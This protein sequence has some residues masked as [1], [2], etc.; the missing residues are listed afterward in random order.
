M[1]IEHKHLYRKYAKSSQKVYEG[2][3][4]PTFV[5]LGPLYISETVEA[6]NLKF[7]IPVDHR[8]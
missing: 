3:N 4:S 1:N 7:G 5:I 2:V 6:R 8:E